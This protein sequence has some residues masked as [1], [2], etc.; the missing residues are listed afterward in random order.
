[1][2]S[3]II[4]NK[5]IEN[6]KLIKKA[7]TVSLCACMVVGMATAASAVTKIASTF[8]EQYMNFPIKVLDIIKD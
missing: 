5:Y 2:K 6:C 3:K 8:M 7:L 4:E 1:M